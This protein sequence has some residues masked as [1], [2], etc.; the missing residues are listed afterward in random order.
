M[1]DNYLSGIFAKAADKAALR[2]YKGGIGTQ[3][4]K[5]VHAVLKYHFE[6]DEKNHEIPFSGYIA[7]I[8]N[9]SGI[10]EIQTRGFKNLRNKL[11]AFLP[12]KKVLVV[13]P[14]PLIVSKVTVDRKT[15]KVVSATKC[16]AAFSKSVFEMNVKERLS[17]LGE[18]WREMFG[19]GEHAASPNL[20]LCAALV[21]AEEI[22]FSDR[23]RRKKGQLMRPT[24][25]HD[26]VPLAVSDEIYFREPSDWLAFAGLKFKMP[27]TSQDYSNAAGIYS[28]TAQTLLNLFNRMNIV[29]RTGKRGN[30]FL[31]MV[32]DIIM[33]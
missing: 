28:E 32:P 29:R 26:L 11:T 4:E 25:K 2:P 22:R 14:V 7:D 30:F 21:E 23:P 10:I 20:S 12:D 8:M 15:E 13:Y 5:S 1:N 6:P 27:F 17:M 24:D 16:R 31:Y 33:S 9:E 19:L 3:G 18:F